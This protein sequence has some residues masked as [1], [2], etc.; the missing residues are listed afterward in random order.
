MPDVANSDDVQTPGRA[1]HPHRL[2]TQGYHAMATKSESAAARR[3]IAET[4]YTYGNHPD[5]AQSDGWLN[6]K[7]VLKDGRMFAAGGGY[8]DMTGLVEPYNYR[9]AGAVDELA[10]ALGLDVEDT[11]QLLHTDCPK[12]W[13]VGSFALGS[14]VTGGAGEDRDVGT[15]VEAIGPD[16]QHPMA[17][18]GN[19]VFVAWDS[20]VRTWTPASDLQSA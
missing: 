9:D 17:A 12:E 2:P 10:E 15:V 11:M 18:N 7:V 19:N 14:R 16:A 4:S 6:G 20:G 5:A 13:T 3:L 1:I 8:L